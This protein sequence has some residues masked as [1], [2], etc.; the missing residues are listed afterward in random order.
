MLAAFVSMTFQELNPPPSLRPSND[1]SLARSDLSSMSDVSSTLSSRLYD[2]NRHSVLSRTPSTSS[3]IT[4][5]TRQLIS[6]FRG[7]NRHVDTVTRSLLAREAVDQAGMPIK[8]RLAFY[9]VC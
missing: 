4:H 5:F 7:S 6:G 3:S 1:V 2:R 9:V 8:R